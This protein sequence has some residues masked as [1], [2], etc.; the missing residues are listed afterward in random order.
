LSAVRHEFKLSAFDS[1][2]A[3][4]EYIRSPELEQANYDQKKKL[5]IARYYCVIRI[6]EA[7]LDGGLI[8]KASDAKEQGNSRSTVF[9]L[10]PNI[11]Q[12]TVQFQTCQVRVVIRKSQNCCV[13]G[14]Q[15]FLRFATLVWL[16]L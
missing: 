7:K 14:F 11:Q 2:R 3:P 15:H 16:V 1:S 13:G 4:T 5:I 6:N 10:K 8:S 12:L 9:A